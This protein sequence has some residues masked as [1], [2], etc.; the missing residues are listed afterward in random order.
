MK[1]DQALEYLIKL[2]RQGGEFPDACWT[3]SQ[4]FG[5]SYSKLQEAY[6]EA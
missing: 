3:A 5:V 4:K 1:L 2:I 6:D